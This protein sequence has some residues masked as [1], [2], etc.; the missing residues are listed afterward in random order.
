MSFKFSGIDQS[1]TAE[2]FFWPFLMI[3]GAII[4]LK[5]LIYDKKLTF[6]DVKLETGFL[7]FLKNL[8]DVFRVFFLCFVINE[9]VIDV[10]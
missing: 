5:Y 2:N 9:D 7:Q 6:V 8:L 3:S 4:K 1:K 10:C